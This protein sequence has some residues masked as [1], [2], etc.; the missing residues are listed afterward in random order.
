[1]R[2]P[3]YTFAVDFWYSIHLPIP[4]WSAWMESKLY[5]CFLLSENA[6]PGKQQMKLQ[7]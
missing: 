7:E 3:E 5:L 6:H 2:D 1:M 4:N